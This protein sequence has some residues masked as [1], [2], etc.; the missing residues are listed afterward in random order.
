[1]STQ[2]AVLTLT[3]APKALRRALLFLRL[4]LRLLLALRLATLGMAIVSPP[5]AIAVLF[6]RLRDIW[7]PV[8]LPEAAL[9]VAVLLAV[10]TAAA[11]RLPEIAV[12]AAA[13][14]RLGLK[15]RVGSALQFVR[16]A[17]PTGMERATILDALGHLWLLRPREAFPLRLPRGA[18]TAAF[19]LAALVLA[20]VLPI[21]ALLLS[22]RE[23]EERAELREVAAKVEPLAKDLEQ[24]AL[25][26][27]DEEAE[28]IARELRKLAQ[29]LHRGQLDKKRALVALSEL[30]QQLQQLDQRLAQARPKTAAE[31]AEK[32]E[33]SARESL[34]EKAMKLARQAAARGDEEAAERL[35]K[36]AEQA[37]SAETSQL[38]QLSQQ[39]SQE[40]AE[41]GAGLGL[42]PE[43]LS[44]LSET[45]AGA[46]IELSKQALENLAAAAQDW[47]KS[48][49]EADLKQL[50]AE[51]EALSELLSEADLKE[52][53][54][55]LAEAAECL[56]AGECDRAADLLGECAGE[57][58]A[59]G[60]SASDLASAC[61][62]AALGLGS[63]SGSGHGYGYGYGYGRGVLRQDQIPPNAPATQLF[64]PRTNENPGD[65][66]RVR[67]QIR[68]GADMMTT[69]EKGAPVKITESRVPYYEVI[70]EYSKTAEEAINREEV[71]ASYRGTVRA[72]FHALQS[73]SDSADE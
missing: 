46:S 52:L 20:Q 27:D 39:L 29:Q 45:L 71:P 18:K 49:S 14:R 25:D 63:C 62:A 16:T 73:G 7:Y 28:H 5:A 64:A 4:R 12:A 6:C 19:G 48:L 54:K 23:R 35:R 56:N 57:L 41:M 40:A 50:A 33:K 30:D 51:L 66:A 55:L 44:A 38:S 13:D 47:G 26:A 67:G 59:A 58:A 53:A 24:A 72:Y 1:M 17:A 43:V 9:G 37:S 11:W 65:L 15:D 8:F 69:T 31:A 22:P 36:L 42:S 21:P 3:D 68:P 10:F 60:L 61:R 32:L 34:A 2:A 70:G